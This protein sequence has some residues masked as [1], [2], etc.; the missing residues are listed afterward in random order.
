MVHVRG[1]GELGQQWYEDGKFLKKRN[2]FNDYL[3]ACD[4]YHFTGF[5]VNLPQAGKPPLTLFD[6]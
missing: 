1:G 3:D 5:T 2:T 4:A 6:H